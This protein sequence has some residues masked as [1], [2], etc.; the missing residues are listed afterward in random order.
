MNLEK[1]NASD[2]KPVTT[3][4][5]DMVLQPA[6]ALYIGGAGNVRVTTVAGTDVLFSAVPVGTILPIKVKRVW[7]TNTTATLIIALYP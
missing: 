2:A 4:D 5:S 6:I 7:A 3:A 1:L